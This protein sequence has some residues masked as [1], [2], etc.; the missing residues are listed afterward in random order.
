MPIYCDSVTNSLCGSESHLTSLGFD[1]FILL[2]I[3]CQ[4]YIPDL[5]QAT[6]CKQL[7]P[8]G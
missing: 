8:Q 7:P 5:N 4:G 3:L 1:D 6:N 2:V